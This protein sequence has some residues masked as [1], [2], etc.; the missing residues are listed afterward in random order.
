VVHCVSERRARLVRDA[1]AIRLEQCGGLQLHPEKTRIVYCKDVNRRGSHEHESFDFLGYEFRP[2]LAVDRRTGQWFTNFTPA[3]SANARKRIG[4][5]IRSWRLHRRSDLTLQDLAKKINNVVRGWINYY[6][7]FRPSELRRL[8]ER[9]DEYLVR[10]AMRKYKRLRRARRRTRQVL[11]DIAS[12][13]PRL[14][15]HWYMIGPS[16]A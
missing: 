5:Q 1:I 6:G 2:R 7:R 4:Q 15:V 9:I 12:R 10:W 13:V 16:K 14:F 8:L 11:A 3:I